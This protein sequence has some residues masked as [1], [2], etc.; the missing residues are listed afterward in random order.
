M[1]KRGNDWYLI[2]GKGQEIRLL[3]HA[4]NLER[5]A[6]RDPAHVAA[7]ERIAVRDPRTEDE[8][9]DNALDQF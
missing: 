5:Q 6:L 4:P 7:R 9:P 3:D 2:N 1:F 8:W